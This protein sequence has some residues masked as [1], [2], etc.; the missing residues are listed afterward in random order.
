[1]RRPNRRGPATLRSVGGVFFSRKCML[2]GLVAFRHQNSIYYPYLKI[3][4]TIL[5]A[6]AVIHVLVL[7]V[8]AEQGYCTKESSAV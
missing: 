2:R 6:L 5:T 3:G 7:T 8:L 4:A 1:M